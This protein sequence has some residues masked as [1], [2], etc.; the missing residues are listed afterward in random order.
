MTRPDERVDLSAAADVDLPLAFAEWHRMRS[1]GDRIVAELGRKREATLLA[2]A[3]HCAGFEAVTV[4]GTTLRATRAYTL[5]STLGPGLRLVTCGLNPSPLAAEVGVG[6][7]RKGNRFWPAIVAAGIVEHDR[8]PMDAI[9]RFGIGMTDLVKRPSARAD[10]ITVDEYRD[11]M[12]RLGRLA[13]W[14]EPD[15]ICMVGLDGWRKVVDR[16][17]SSGWQPTELGGRPVYVMPNTSGLNA[18]S[19]PADFVAHLQR[20]MAGP[21]A[22]SSV[23]A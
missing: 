10:E 18:S 23:N 8:D 14:L 13:A 9:R 4:R 5:A 12:A 21:S 2:D 17:A 19:T 6:F 15:A 3:M 20:A 16:K 22:D 1:V 11:G 7:A